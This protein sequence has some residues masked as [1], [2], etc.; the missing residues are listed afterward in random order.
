MERLQ[1]QEDDQLQQDEKALEN[2]MDAFTQLMSKGYI[3]SSEKI[4]DRLL[5]G[6]WELN[7]KQAAMRRQVYTHIAAL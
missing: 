5:V 2:V 1:H 7:R 4:R 6:E 3:Q